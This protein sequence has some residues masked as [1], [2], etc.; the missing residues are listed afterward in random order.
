L[1]GRDRL[2]SDLVTWVIA[3][4]VRYQ[5]NSHRDRGSVE[6]IRKHG[7]VVEEA[8]YMC[9]HPIHVVEMSFIVDQ[10]VNTDECT[11]PTDSPIIQSKN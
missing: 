4:M 6:C 3:V 11:R 5:T 2:A 7:A 9:P 10:F 1:V 8:S